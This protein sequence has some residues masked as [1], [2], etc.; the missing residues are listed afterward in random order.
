MPW[1]SMNRVVNGDF[2]IVCKPLTDKIASARVLSDL[3]VP[4]K[5]SWD[6]GQYPHKGIVYGYCARLALEKSISHRAGKHYRYDQRRRLEHRDSRH[7]LR[8]LAT[9]W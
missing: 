3:T 8:K 7:A 4:R 5:G 2:H 9:R 1:S 6:S